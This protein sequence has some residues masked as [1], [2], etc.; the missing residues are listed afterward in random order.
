MVG[1]K[2]YTIAGQEFGPWQGKIFIIVKALYG[3]K[4][5][6]FMWHQK[7]SDNLREY[8]ISAML[9]RLRFMHEIP[10]WLLWIHCGCGGW[11]TNIWK[12]S[13]WSY[14]NTPRYLE[15]LIEGSRGAG[16]QNCWWY[17]VQWRKKVLYYVVQELYQE[18]LWPNWEAPW[19]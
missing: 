5:S 8:G 4:S 11:S 12:V 15:L 2:L 17:W 9:C 18:R 13:A 7:F 16:V 3:L 1:E 14:W 6:N 19:N 10:R